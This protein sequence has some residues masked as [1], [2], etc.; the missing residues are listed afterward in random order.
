MMVLVIGLQPEPVAPVVA[1]A[2]ARMNRTLAHRTKE[3]LETSSAKGNANWE[4]FEAK[5]VA[6]E[7]AVVLDPGVH[8]LCR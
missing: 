2:R 7:V 4:R 8:R 6:V 5:E 3:L 1:Q